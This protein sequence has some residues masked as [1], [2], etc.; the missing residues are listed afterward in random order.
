LSKPSRQSALIGLLISAAGFAGFILMRR[1]DVGF[2]S[3]SIALERENEIWRV[4]IKA[5]LSFRGVA[6]NAELFH[7][8]VQRID[9]ISAEVGAKFDKLCEHLIKESADLSTIDSTA[10]LQMD[11]GHIFKRY[12]DFHRRLAEMRHKLFDEIMKVT[13]DAVVG[14]LENKLPGQKVQPGIEEGI[15]VS[16]SYPVLVDTRLLQKRRAEWDE[17]LRGIVSAGAATGNKIVGEWIERASRGDIKPDDLP[18]VIQL[19]QA[20][21]GRTG[22]DSI[23]IPGRLSAPAL[24]VSPTAQELHDWLGTD[25]SIDDPAVPGRVRAFFS[26]KKLLLAEC[27]S[28][29]VSADQLLEF[30][31]SQYGGV[32]TLGSIAAAFARRR[33]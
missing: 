17:T 29:E 31:R 2:W 13:Y 27:N 6:R 20:S 16:I 25:R 1:R 28:P 11:V 18:A 21:C 15:K 14:I 22:T 30:V 3:K 33:G 7:Q 12:A 8:V 23:A 10:R 5:E 24:E 32:L 9:F 4:S 26:E 19:I